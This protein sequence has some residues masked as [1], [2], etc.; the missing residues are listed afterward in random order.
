MA[1]CGVVKK[2]KNKLILNLKGISIS[3]LLVDDLCSALLLLTPEHNIRQCEI[4]GKLIYIAP[5]KK[6]KK[7]TSCT[8]TIIR[9]EDHL[10]KK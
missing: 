4:K 1:L 10:E 9:K 8:V 6:N 7:K 3:T 2:Q 5:I